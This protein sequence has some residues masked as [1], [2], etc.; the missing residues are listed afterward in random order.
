MPGL[1]MHLEFGRRLA[2]E[3]GE[4]FSFMEDLKRHDRLFGLGCQGPDFLLYHAFQ[5]WHKE[6]RA[7]RLGNAM[8]RRQCGQAMLDFW[9]KWKKLQ[10]ED[11]AMAGIYFFGFLTHHVLDRNMHPYINWKAGYGFRDHQRF[12]MELDTIF[13]KR[14]GLNTWTQKSWELIDAGSRLPYPVLVIL[15]G[16]ALE[17]YPEETGGLDP[18]QWHGAYRDMVTAQRWLYDPLGWKRRVLPGKSRFLLPRPL[19]AAE[20]NLDYLNERGTQ[21][22]HSAAYSEVRSESVADLWEQALDDARA[23]LGGLAE[24]LAAE[25]KLGPD[26]RHT[27]E[28]KRERFRLALGDRSYDTGMECGTDAVNRYAQPIW[29]WA[30][31]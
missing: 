25:A 31:A 6:S 18:D 13:M 21:W 11:A 2:Q 8:H 29:K 23:V 1:W 7:V 17:R 26:S 30:G 3:F 16:T 10:G 19:S 28:N 12:E 14:R 22:R 20:E 9:D 27:A 15:H 5:P 24:W 4:R